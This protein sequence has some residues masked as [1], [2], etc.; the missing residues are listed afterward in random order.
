M[1]LSSAFVALEEAITSDSTWIPKLIIP[2][3]YLR[4]GSEGLIEV[5]NNETINHIDLFTLLNYPSQNISPILSSLKNEHNFPDGA[6]FKLDTEFNGDTKE[7]RENIIKFFNE[8]SKL[9]GGTEFIITT[10]KKS[11]STR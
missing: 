7:T 1:K 5:N 4:V 10:S 8:Y 3:K 2:T 6:I 9:D 11:T